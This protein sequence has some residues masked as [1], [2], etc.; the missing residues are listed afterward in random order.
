M[1]VA[2]ARSAAQRSDAVREAVT[3]RDQGEALA[4]EAT[5]TARADATRFSADVQAFAQA[6]Q[7]MTL[8]R[9]LQ[10]LGKALNRARITIVDHRLTIEGGTTLD[11]RTT[12]G[13]GTE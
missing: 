7:A 12:P 10:T 4:A 3:R 5:A 8:E 2:R 13:S 11:L 6:P 9:R 1:A